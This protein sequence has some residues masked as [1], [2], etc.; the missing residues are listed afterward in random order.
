[1]ASMPEKM[2][3]AAKKETRKRWRWETT[4]TIMS[5]MCTMEPISDNS[6]Y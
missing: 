6:I 4:H 5:M 3:M 1:M 2:A